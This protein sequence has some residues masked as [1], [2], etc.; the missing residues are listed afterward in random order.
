VTTLCRDCASLTE[1][2]PPESLVNADAVVHLAGEP[3]A[4]R[5]TPEV[6]TQI[7]ESRVQGTRRLIEYLMSPLLRY[8]HESLRER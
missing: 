6:K 5:W 2:P 7:R 4:Q 1:E 8:R 3:V